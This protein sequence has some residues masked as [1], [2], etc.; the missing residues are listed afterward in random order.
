MF[1]LEKVWIVAARS[2][3]RYLRVVADRW[4]SAEGTV[5]YV[6]LNDNHIEIS[7]GPVWVVT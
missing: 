5:R 6:G 1:A 7:A 3:C 2:F 4:L